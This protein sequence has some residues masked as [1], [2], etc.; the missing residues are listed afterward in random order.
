ME[1]K[2]TLLYFVC[3]IAAF[4]SFEDGLQIS[5]EFGELVKYRMHAQVILQ[6][7][8]IKIF[9]GERRG[10]NRYYITFFYLN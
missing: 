8:W 6:C 4:V 9:R 2:F 1:S 3:S 5:F 10:R 7:V